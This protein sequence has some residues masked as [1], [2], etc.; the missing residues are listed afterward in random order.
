VNINLTLLGELITFL[1]FS[2]VTMKFVWPMILTAIEERQ[3]TI[4]DGLAAAD[5][6]QKELSLAEDKVAKQLLKSREH[7][8]TIIDQAEKRAS[9][10]VDDAKQQ[11]KE[12]GRR[13]LSS[14]QSEIEREVEQSKQVL[15]ARFAKLA[16]ACAEK[17]IKSHIDADKNNALLTQM[18]EEL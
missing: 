17:L 10:I 11:A 16:I 15:R 8:Q 2:L 7:A 14:A 12:E 6:S 1:V 3:K 5:R 9:Q 18:A 4:A 13:I